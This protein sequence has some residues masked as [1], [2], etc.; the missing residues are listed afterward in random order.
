[1]KNFGRLL[2]LIMIVTCLLAVRVGGCQLFPD[3]PNQTATPSMSETTPASDSTTSDQSG[4]QST[5]TDPTTTAATTTYALTGPLSDNNSSLGWS[6]IYADPPGEDKPTS[7]P[8]DIRDLV[9]KYNVIWQAP[10]EW[11]QGCLPDI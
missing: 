10:P 7:I 8:G 1:M 6:F 11:P 4:T 5:T 2:P 3:K 9:V